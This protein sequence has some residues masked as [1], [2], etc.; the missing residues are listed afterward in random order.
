MVL[1]SIRHV[2]VRII[3][4]TGDGDFDVLLIKDLLPRLSEYNAVESDGDLCKTL[5]QKISQA[6]NGA[7]QVKLKLHKGDNRPQGDRFLFSL[8]SSFPVIHKVGIVGIFVLLKFEKKEKSFTLII[9]Q[10]TM[11]NANLY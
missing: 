11:S 6:K 10:R 5:E 2:I 8:H 4:H 9:I 7:I 1:C 3:T